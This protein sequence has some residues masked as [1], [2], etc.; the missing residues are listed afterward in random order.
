MEM[1]IFDCDGVLVD[2]EAIA[3]A[4]LVERLA[5]WLPDVDI[6]ARLGEALGLTT[7]AI[8]ERLAAFSRHDLPA[9]ALG[10]MDAEIERRLALEL[11]AID[12]VKEAI[13]ELGMSMAVVSNSHRGRV[14]ASL[15]HTGLN[16][17]LG[18]SPIFC[19][20]QVARP[21]PDPAVYRLAID[22]LGCRPGECLV[23]E[24]SVA[25]VTAACAAGMTVVGFTGASHVMPGQA[26]RL[27]AAGSWQVM[28]RMHELPGL[29]AQWRQTGPERLTGVGRGK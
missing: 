22:E 1:L 10:A 7:A 14:R 2:S 8:L 24:D 19:A 27:R 13:C 20:E 17:C 21:K 4:T 29:V 25:G 26:E 28:A 6:H 18:D 15:V 3:E 12:G 16:A 9:D 23:V 11:T 5:T